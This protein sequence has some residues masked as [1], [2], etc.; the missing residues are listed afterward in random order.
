MTRVFLLVLIAPLLL[1]AQPSITTGALDV[2]YINQPYNFAMQSMGGTPPLTWSQSGLPSGLDIDPDTGIISGTPTVSGE[3]SVTIG[4]LDASDEGEMVMFTLYVLDPLTITNT[5]LF[6]STVGATYEQQMVTTGDYVAPLTWS[7][8]GLPAGLD[9]DAD[10]GIISGSPMV[11]GLFMVTITVVD[12]NMDLQAMAMKEFPLMV[13]DPLVITTAAL[14]DATAGAPYSFQMTTMGGT[15]MQSWDQMGLPANLMI[16]AGGL[17]TGTPATSGSVMVDF[18]VSDG[19]ENNDN[20]SLQLTIQPALMIST[21]SLLDGTVGQT[22]DGAVNATGG[23]PPYLFSWTNQPPGLTMG[24]DGSITGTPTM[25]GNY[26]PTVTVTDS[27]MVMAQKDLGLL[28][29]PPPL[30]ISTTSLP[31]GTV[32]Q[33]Y[34]SSVAATGGTPPYS[35]SWTNQPPGLTMGSDGSITGTP[36][37]ASNYT[38]TVTV[39]DS[40]MVMTQKDLGLLVNPPALVITTTSLPERWGRPTARRWPQPA[41]RRRIRSS[42]RTSRRG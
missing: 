31:D 25:A 27:A 12:S 9:I 32:G 4:V 36:T 13:Y 8:S 7:Q 34:S 41:G 10:T 22:Y 11:S 35:F 30:V 29:N 40:L 18:V 23:T 33:T 28:V 37:T 39:T 24:S 17:I 14:P 2:A 42:G 19:L 15:P 1:V 21:T 26:T 38:A 5:Y 6:S 20:V 16:S 3:F